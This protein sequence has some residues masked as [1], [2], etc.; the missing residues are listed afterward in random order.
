[1]KL[2]QYTAS[3]L[4]VAM[5]VTNSGPWIPMA[6]ANPIVPDAGRLGPQMDEARNG[7]TIVNINTPN[8]R[9]LS[10]N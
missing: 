1:M 8:G 3:A 5:L 10:H 9:G 6:L 4:L 2:K 7:T